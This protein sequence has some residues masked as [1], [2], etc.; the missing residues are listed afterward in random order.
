[1]IATILKSTT[2]FSAVYYNERKVSK[3][4]ATL[5]EIKNFGPVGKFGVY[6]P[7]ELVNYLKLYTSRNDRI[8]KPQFHLAISCKGQ[9]MTQEELLDFAHDY[10][11]EMGYA[12]EGQPLLIYSHHDT[13]NNHL[14]IIT[15]RISPDGRKINHSNERRRSQEVIDKLLGKSKTEKL[16]M[17]IGIAKSYSFSNLI[18]FKAILMSLGYECFERVDSLLI[19]K[20]GKI[21]KKIEIPEL[22]QLY[23]HAERDYSLESQLRARLLKYRDLSTNKE[24]LA[25]EI[26]KNFG[27]DI[28]YFG[29]KDSPNGFILVDHHNKKVIPGGRIIDI[30]SLIDFKSPEERRR[31]MLSFVYKLIEEN[32]RITVPL[33]NKKIRRYG[34][35]IKSSKLFYSNDNSIVLNSDC[36]E[37]LKRNMKLSLI[38]SFAP[39]SIHEIVILCR[40]FKV[41]DSHTEINVFPAQFNRKASIR[42]TM[43]GELKIMFDQFKGKELRDAIKSA[44]YRL[45]R[46]DNECFAIDFSSRS[47]LHLNREGFNVNRLYPDTIIN[48]QNKDLERQKTG[49]MEVIQ[50]IKKSYPSCQGQNR[51]WEIKKDQYDKVDESIDSSLSY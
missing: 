17:D 13:A 37:R 51:E 49:F 14:H 31:E 48:Y 22:E 24:E 3:G 30:R 43:R 34:A 12:E 40:I 36:V 27:I 1:M 39:Q 33:I 50:S 10:L 45:K 46:N 29:K 38:E 20:G 47:I 7:E 15:S 18:Q 32:P 16:N 2:T 11:T 42:L 6:T 4:D 5:I 44:G 28:V 8:T 21:L 25:L 23:R 41:E 19:K 35:R 9:E 26:K